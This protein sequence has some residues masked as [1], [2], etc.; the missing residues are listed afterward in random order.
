MNTA[1]HWLASRSGLLTLLTL[2]TLLGM[3][4][5]AWRLYTPP[6]PPPPL[7]IAGG[8]LIQ[9]LVAE[10]AQRFSQQTGE[11]VQVEAGG[12]MAGMAAVKRGAIDI[13]MVGQPVPGLFSDPQTRQHLL[14]RNSLAFIVHHQSPVRNLSQAQIRQA[15]T[16]QVRNWKALG[17]PDAPIEVLTWRKPALIALF[18]EWMVLGGQ[19]V[20]HQ[21]KQ[22][23]D[24]S[25]M[26]ASVAG[27]PLALGYVS[28][29]DLP[30]RAAVRP[31]S[32]DGA[33]FSRA[34]ILS[35]HYPYIQD[36]YLVGY[37]ACKPQETAFMRFISTP[38][39][40]AIIA[41]HNLAP[42][43]THATESEPHH[44]Q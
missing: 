39:V 2:A 1:R 14:A 19:S 41:R 37:C 21:A 17:G 26:L 44:G 7:L 29:Q 25:D 34:T 33:P 24:A 10:L 3:L 22:V 11:E 12:S 27:N 5:V 13:A 8:R 30:S 40:K 32:I 6:P 35:G 9:P 42:G 28:L 23:D 20:T 31:L 4:G 16:G 43:Y 15:L 36:M 38:E 18:V